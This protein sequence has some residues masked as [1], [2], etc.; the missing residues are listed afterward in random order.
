[1]TTDTALQAAYEKKL[2]QS[3]FSGALELLK[4][5]LDASPSNVVL[6]NHQS[7]LQKKTG[8]VFDA[9]KTLEQAVRLDATYAASYNHLGLLYHQLH[10]HEKAEHFF[11]QALKQ[12]SDYIDAMYNLAL[13]YKVQQKMLDASSALMAL[14]SAASGHLPAHFLLAKIFLSAGKKQKACER[15]AMIAD[16]SDNAQN[17]LAE[18]IALLLADNYFIEAEPFCQLSLKQNPS[19]ATAHYNLGVIYERMRN[20]NPA[21][22]YYQKAIDLKADYFEALN[23]IGVL[24]LEKQ[25]IQTAA[26]Y[27]KK[28]M[29]LQPE[30]KSLQHTYAAVTGD[31]SVQ[32]ASKE[33]IS[34]LF[35]QYAGHFDEHLQ[36]GL[37]YQ[38]PELLAQQLRDRVDVRQ[39]QWDVLDL[40]CGTGLA[41]A[42]VRPWAKTLTGIDLSEK[43]LAQAKKKNLFTALHQDDCVEGLEKYQHFFDLVI[44]AD[45]FVYWG[46]V[47][48]LFQALAKAMKPGGLLS[49]SIELTEG[50]A[51]CLSPSGRFHHAFAYIQS[52]AEKHAFQLLDFKKAQTRTQNEKAVIGGLFLLASPAG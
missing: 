36:V 30:N 1:M 12:Q 24:Y 14:L 7:M 40:G 22:T 21:I 50:N 3:D 52:E 39:A 32:S 18:I 16:L 9:I 11:L 37:R 51:F 33:Y 25:Q 38:V 29:A 44:A 13:T 5:L 6:L 41:G 2:Q 48:P 28:A 4:K 49:F 19:N 15:F 45:V 34:A 17:V 43:M 47:T 35:D 23:N 10:E 26:F 46:N 20:I 42:A 27:L 8:H 31:Q